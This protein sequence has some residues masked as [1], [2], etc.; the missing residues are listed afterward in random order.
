[1]KNMPHMEALLNGSRT[2]VAFAAT[3]I[4]GEF[5]VRLYRLDANG[6]RAYLTDGYYT[7]DRADAIA[8]AGVMLRT[9]IWR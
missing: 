6:R 7:D 2:V 1:M 3:S 8:T 5:R 4:R 9:A